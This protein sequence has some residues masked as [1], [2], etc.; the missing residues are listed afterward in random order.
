M[1]VRTYLWEHRRPGR[2]SHPAV[3]QRACWEEYCCQDRPFPDRRCSRRSCICTFAFS[4]LV[5]KKLARLLQDILIV[6]FLE[7]ILMFGLLLRQELK[8]PIHLFILR[9]L[10][11]TGIKFEGSLFHLPGHSE[12]IGI[13][14]VGP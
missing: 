13:G 7:R 11:E 10:L 4:L 2:P 1:P 5:K 14:K 6:L 3:S 8:E 12:D 9:R